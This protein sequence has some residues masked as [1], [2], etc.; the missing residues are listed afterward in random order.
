VLYSTFQTSG[1]SASESHAGLMPQER[2]LLF[3]IM[4]ITA[5]TEN[6]IL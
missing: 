3:L 4:E 5:C 6:P 1:A 2:V